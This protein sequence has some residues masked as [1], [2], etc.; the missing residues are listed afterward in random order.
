MEKDELTTQR[1]FNLVDDDLRL[2]KYE[3]ELDQGFGRQIAQMAHGEKFKTCIQCGTCSATCPVSHF[4]DYTPR[5]IIAMVRAG[6][7]EEVLRSFT[8]WI[9]ASCHSCTAECPR[10]IKITDVM[11]AL[12]QLAIKEGIYP[13]RFPIPVMAKE[14]Y[15]IV[16][17][18]GRNSEGR[19]MIN[20]AMRTNPFRLLRYAKVGLKLFTTGRA[21]LHEESIQNKREIKALLQA[22][23]RAKEAAK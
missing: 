23:D 2:I 5:K 20:I 16:E 14:F 13:K 11:Y 21:S 7:R 22:M 18:Q 15:K 1:L 9:C 8:I 12:K 3:A 17:K 6:F 19:L 4:M 10:E